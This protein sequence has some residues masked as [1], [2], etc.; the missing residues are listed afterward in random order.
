VEPKLEILTLEVLE[1]IMGDLTKLTADVASQ[2]ALIV[3]LQAHVTDLK[4]Q[5]AAALASSTD[6][7]AIDAVDAT[8]ESNNAAI[9]AAT[10]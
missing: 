7:A 5:L 4:N 3:T 8:V 1:R 9:T 2:T 6:Q 10:A